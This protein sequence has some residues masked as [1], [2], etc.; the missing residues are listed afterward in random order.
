MGSTE[1]R[2]FFGMLAVLVIVAAL[3]F[4]QSL[5]SA[6]KVDVYGVSV[7]LCGECENF[8]KGLNGAALEKNVDMHIV[9]AVGAS[10]EA[11]TAALERELNNGAGA[12]VLYL[13]DAKNLSVWLQKNKAAVPLVYVG[14]APVKGVSNVSLEAT[15]LAAALVSEL[16]SQPL[17]SITLVGDGEDVDEARINVLSAAF[18]NAGFTYDFR[19]PSE[20]KTLTAECIYVAA[21]PAASRALIEIWSEGALLYGM[22]YEAALRAPLENGHIAAL[23]T[24]SEFDA[25]YLAVTEAVARIDGARASD[26]ALSA[27]LARSGNMYEP[28]VSTILFPIG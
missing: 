26:A 13:A 21:S 20:M 3:Y 2:I 18:S 17:R 19:Y 11:Q 23:A 14:D 12:V 22:G 1:K 6:R 5:D 8:E 27:F 16:E 28:P 24:V 4:Y 25:G 10:P 9:R 7:I 15:A